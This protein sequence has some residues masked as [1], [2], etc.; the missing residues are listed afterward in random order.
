LCQHQNKIADAQAGAEE[1]REV[2]CAIQRGLASGAN[3]QF[4]FGLFEGLIGHFH[5]NLHELIDG[6]SCL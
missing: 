5:R 3:E 2:A 4:E 6:E 1:D